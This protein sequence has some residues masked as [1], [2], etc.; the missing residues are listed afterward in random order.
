MV[1]VTS[2]EVGRALYHL[3]KSGNG[4][5][6]VSEDAAPYLERHTEVRRAIRRL[7]DGTVE[8]IEH[9]IIDERIY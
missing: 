9:E 3:L 7:P 5:E 4:I 6:A 2:D 1:H 8:I